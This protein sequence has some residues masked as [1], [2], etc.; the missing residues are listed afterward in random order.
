[1][2][3]RGRKGQ[4]SVIVIVALVILAGIVIYFGF[5][6]V[7]VSSVPSELEPVYGYYSECIE[8]TTED[9]LKI[10]GIQ[11]GR[12]YLE[13]YEPGSSYSPFGNQLRFL[14]SPVSY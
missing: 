12:I 5:R 6:N 11:G 7:N 4:L 9:A 13:N 14:G 1:M 8:S 2:F 3:I 10:A